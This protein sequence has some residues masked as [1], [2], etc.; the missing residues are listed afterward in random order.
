MSRYIIRLATLGILA[1]SAACTGAQ[2]EFILVD[3]APVST[4]PTY[5]SK[6]K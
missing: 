5:T 2:E 1:I 3:P 6:Y 4:E